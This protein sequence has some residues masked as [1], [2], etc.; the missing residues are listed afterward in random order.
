MW[1]HQFSVMLKINWTET[2]TQCK[3][4]LML[5]LTT[6]QSILGSMRGLS[7]HQ[8]THSLASRRVDLTE[9]YL[10]FMAMRIFPRESEKGLFKP[11][12]KLIIDGTVQP[13]LERL[14]YTVTLPCLSWWR[15]HFFNPSFLCQVSWTDSECCWHRLFIF[16]SLINIHKP[17]LFSLWT[18]GK[19]LLIS[20][21]ALQ[22]NNKTSVLNQYWTFI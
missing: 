7:P 6:M 21:F 18:G 20:P 10:S 5:V 15:R 17:K 14:P 22:T 8:C 12:L 19:T 1:V 2:K 9:V 4:Q 16:E 3:V 13:N 11:L